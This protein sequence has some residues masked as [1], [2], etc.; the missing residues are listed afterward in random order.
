VNLSCDMSSTEQT[1]GKDCTLL[2]INL[3]MKKI[4]QEY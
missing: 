1:L 4:N 2:T 3:L